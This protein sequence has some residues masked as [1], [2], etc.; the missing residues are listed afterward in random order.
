MGPAEKLLADIESLPVTAQREVA[1]FVAFLRD[2]YAVKARPSAGPLHESKFVG[3]WADREE[4][5]DS[6]A[7]LRELRRQQWGG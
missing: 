2:K 6:G 5:R 4:M 1:D 7:W 3:I